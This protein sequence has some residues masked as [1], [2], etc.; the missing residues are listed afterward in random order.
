MIVALGF[1]PAGLHAD[2][3]Q[4]TSIHIEP[5]SPYRHAFTGHYGNSRADYFFSS[6]GDWRDAR[7]RARL[8]DI[9]RATAGDAPRDLDLYSL[10]VYEKTA[11]LNAGFDG[12][13]GAL[14]GVHDTDLI[15]YARWNHG[16]M[17]VFYLIEDG[18]VVHD[19]LTDEAVDPPWEFD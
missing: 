16:N 12:D 1:L 8:A 3:K 11:T 5:L 19:M 18:N 9:V 17:D 10:Y 15:S 2:N 7:Y 6:R 13:A 4:Q 14:R